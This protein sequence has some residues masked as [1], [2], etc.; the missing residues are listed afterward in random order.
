M[1]Y[2]DIFNYLIATPSPYTQQQ[3]RAYKSLEAY[4]Y[5][6]DGWISNVSVVPV[7]TCP[8]AFLV[9]ACVKH[10]QKLSATLVKPWV[11]VKQIGTVLCCHCTCMAGLGEAC[12]H[13][14]SVLF[15]LEAN[16]QLKKRTSCTSLPCSWLP[17]SFQNVPYAEIADIDFENPKL[18]RRKM[19]EQSSSSPGQAAVAITSNH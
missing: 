4:K 18:K 13:I 6:V 19:L 1:E 10:S 14:A 8:G 16:T 11:A 12:S 3:L 5:F 17:P 2:P 15:A 7:S 9:T